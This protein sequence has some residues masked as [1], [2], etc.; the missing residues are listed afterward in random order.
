VQGHRGAWY[1]AQAMER[2]WVAIGFILTV[3]VLFHFAVRPRREFL[4][5]I[6]DGRVVSALGA[7][8]PRFLEDVE[9]VCVFWGIQK[10]KVYGIRRGRR[11]RLFVGGGIEK[12]HA[13]AF[14]NAWENPV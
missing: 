10:G 7:A 13:Q 12:K 6:R 11:V 2:Y 8:T 4:I 3:V 1:N 5:L 9:K 14:Q